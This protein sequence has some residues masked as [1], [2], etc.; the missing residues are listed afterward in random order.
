[1][2]K[3]DNVNFLHEKTIKIARMQQFM[4]HSF[5]GGFSI[6]LDIY[7]L[8]TFTHKFT[9]K[10]YPKAHIFIEVHLVLVGGT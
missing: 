6:V 10:F 3:D 4:S 9:H 7:L 2:Q 8:S 1:M 5:F